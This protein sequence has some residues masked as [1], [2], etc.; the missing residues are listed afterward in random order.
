MCTFVGIIY[1]M[2]CS[3]R[4]Y[5]RRLKAIR[6]TLESSPFFRSHEVCKN[7]FSFVLFQ[8]IISII[9]EGFLGINPSIHLEFPMIFHEV[10]LNISCNHP[11]YLLNKWI[12]FC[13]ACGQVSREFI[14]AWTPGELTVCES[15]FTWVL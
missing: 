7:F 11:C 12:P 4:K 13:F 2:F 15:S 14:E 5:L 9:M 8:D 3:Q 10:S 1:L 6:A